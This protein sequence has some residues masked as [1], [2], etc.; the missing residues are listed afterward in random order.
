MHVSAMCH[1]SNV[2]VL[3]VDLFIHVPHPRMLR[4]HRTAPEFLHCPRLFLS[5]DLCLTCTQ[6]HSHKHPCSGPLAHLLLC[7]P[8]WGHRACSYALLYANRLELDKG[9][10]ERYGRCASEYLC[11]LLVPYRSISSSLCLSSPS[12]IFTRVLTGSVVPDSI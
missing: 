12:L 9:T 2:C 6:P 5:V 4:K 10:L 11:V 1:S 8:V 7:H 3:L